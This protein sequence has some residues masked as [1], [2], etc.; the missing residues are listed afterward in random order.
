MQCIASSAPSRI[1]TSPTLK[2]LLIGNELGTQKTSP[3]NCRC[4]WATAPE[5]TNPSGS[6]AKPGLLER[7][8]RGR[9][10]A[11]VRRDRGEVQRAAQRDEPHPRDP[12]VGTT[13]TATT[14]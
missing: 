5:L 4:G 1:S 7:V 12:A 3:R 2:T 9:H 13:K 11:A 10:D 8:R 6:S 14:T